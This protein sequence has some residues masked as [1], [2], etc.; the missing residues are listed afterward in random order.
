MFCFFFISFIQ[1]SVLFAIAMSVT[2][3]SGQFFGSYDNSY[4]F[5]YDSSASLDDSS[6]GSSFGGFGGSRFRDPRQNRGK[7]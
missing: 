1:T 3:V 5:G 4:R 7:Q 2:I 6:S